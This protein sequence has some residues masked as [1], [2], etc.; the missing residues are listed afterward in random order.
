ME[1]F[2][3]HNDFANILFALG[4]YLCQWNKPR[5]AMKDIQTYKNMK[6]LFENLKLI[7]SQCSVQN[8]GCYPIQPVKVGNKIGF[9]DWET[10]SLEC[11]PLFD[12]FDREFSYQ[13]HHICVCKGDKWG[14]LSHAFKLELSVDYSYSIANQ[15][16]KVLNNRYLYSGYTTSFNT[17]QSLVN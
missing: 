8:I 17:C 1:S 16:C 15:V 12:D 3:L 14:V 9:V 7:K 11:V 13:C 2:Y 4:L 5:E 6:A 10:A